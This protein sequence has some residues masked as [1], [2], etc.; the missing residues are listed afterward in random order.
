[1][2]N[3]E[4]DFT[5]DISGDVFIGACIFITLGSLFI[6]F[7]GDTGLEDEEFEDEEFDDEEFDDEEFEDEEFE[8][9]ELD[10]GASTS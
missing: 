7:N 4:S 10:S 9:E 5:D 1:L 3:A 8:D 2:Y 6:D